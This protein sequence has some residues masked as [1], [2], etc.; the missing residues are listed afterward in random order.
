MCNESFY[1][2]DIAMVVPGLEAIMGRVVQTVT[3][4]FRILIKVEKGMEH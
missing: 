2:D 1:E 4:A 3:F